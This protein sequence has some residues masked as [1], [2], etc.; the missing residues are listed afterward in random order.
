[1][2]LRIGSPRTHTQLGRLVTMCPL[3]C[4]DISY[5]PIIYSD[6]YVPMYHLFIAYLCLVN[7]ANQSKPPSYIPIRYTLLV[8]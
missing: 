1:M 6:Q 5:I 3:G 8:A 4:L 2:I 7:P